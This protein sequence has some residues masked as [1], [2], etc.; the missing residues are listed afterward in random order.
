MPKAYYN[1]NKGKTRI[2]TIIM[3][4]IRRS[5]YGQRFQKAHG[6]DGMMSSGQEMQRVKVEEVSAE[7]RAFCSLTDTGR[8]ILYYMVSHVK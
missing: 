8:Q 5:H 3:W 4:K 2:K 6:E 1:H 7:Q